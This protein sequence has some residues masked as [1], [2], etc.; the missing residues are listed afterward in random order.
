MF[1]TSLTMNRIILMATVLCWLLPG[2]VHGQ[3]ERPWERIMEE[4]ID[5]ED[6]EEENWEDTYEMLCA[7]EEK[8]MNLNT[9][10]R[11]ELEIM[12]FLTAR[13]VEALIEYRYRY[14]EMKSMNELR[15][16]KELDY[17]QI[18]LLQQFAYV[19]E[20]EHAD[21][22][23]LRDILRYGHHEFM[24]NA[25]IPFYQ[26]KGDANGYTGYPLKHS[27]RYQFS[28]KDR[29]KAGLIGAQDAG[30][31]FFAGKN[32]TGYDFYSFYL[33]AKQLGHLENMVI[34]RYRLAIGM[35]LIIN[36]SFGMGK[37]TMLQQMGR[38]TSIVRPHSSRSPSA[39]LQGA[40]ATF[41][42]SDLFQMTLAASY[43]ALDAIL[44]EDGTARTLTTDGYH[45][46]PAE[47]SREGNTHAADALLHIT[48]RYHGWHCG[49][50]VMY[51]NLSR[52]LHPN[53]TALYR[54][55]YAHGTNFLNTSVDYG[56]LHP[57]FALSGETAIDRNSH[58]STI[59][60]LSVHATDRLDIM[61]QQRFY[62]YRYTALYAHSPSEGGHV[63]N[64]QAFFVGAHWHPSPY[65]QLQF[66]SDYARFPWA[67]YQ[68]SQPSW[69]WD[70]LLQGSFQKGN[71]TMAGRYRLHLKQKD[72]SKKQ[73]L[74]NLTEHRSRLSMTYHGWSAITVSTQADGVATTGKS[75][76]FG[77]MLTQSA[78]GKW[79]SLRL[80]MLAGYFH[81]DSYNSRIYVYEQGPLYTFSFP[82]YYGEG[83]R[84]ALMVQ[85]ALSDKLT[86]TAK[87]G[88][89]RYFD[90][91]T[92]GSGL[93]EINQS[94]MSDLNL[95]ARWK[96]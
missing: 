52:A 72:D 22:L 66:Y 74:L 29:I 42:L 51:T 58:L 39:F 63:Q 45:R 47:L 24:G 88:Y 71:W 73:Q 14:G 38:S 53:I 31:P 18:T 8:P 17:P 60:S 5:T 16:I 25:V 26:R 59:N 37:L 3:T 67:R 36:N 40:A 77:Y 13:Q 23:R 10:T 87:A 34:G 11:E 1:F 27:L 44:N 91:K 33:Q 92:I 28:Y 41:Y 61:L 81:A 76:T 32:A 95:Q 69:A 21:T 43:R 20:Q 75:A 70:Q 82:A 9:A 35:G 7:L 94:A 15:M 96:F 89:T 4:M 50:T 90:R 79:K 2:K 93:Q 12:P 62:S 19:G 64:E 68:V 6:K 54:R 46:T 85:Y 80:N 78:N 65:L 49:G 55:Y 57:R 30:E 86:L 83:I 84:L 56:Y 48:Y